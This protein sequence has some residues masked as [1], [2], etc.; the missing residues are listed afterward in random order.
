M[1][2]NHHT[3]N[4]FSRQEINSLK[5]TYNFYSPVWFLMQ[6]TLRQRYLPP[7]VLPLIILQIAGTVLEVFHLNYTQAI[8]ARSG[9]DSEVH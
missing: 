4:H 1:S 2:I 7:P 9:Q 5:G 6:E 8:Y 3:K